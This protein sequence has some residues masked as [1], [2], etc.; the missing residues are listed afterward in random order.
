MK[1]G[2]EQSHGIGPVNPVEYLTQSPARVARATR[3]KSLSAATAKKMT[4]TVSSNAIEQAAA[5]IGTIFAP[6]PPAFFP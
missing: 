4:S 1:I 3:P 2:E 6:P 5:E